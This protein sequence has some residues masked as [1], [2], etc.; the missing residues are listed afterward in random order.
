MKHGFMHQ[1]CRFHGREGMPQYPIRGI[2]QHV[3]H[4]GNI[5]SVLVSSAISNHE[6]AVSSCNAMPRLYAQ[7]DLDLCKTSGATAAVHNSD[8]VLISYFY[9]PSFLPSSWM[10]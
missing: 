2:N 4:A 7:K 3:S 5:A 6:G 1:S 10:T 9:C 8:E